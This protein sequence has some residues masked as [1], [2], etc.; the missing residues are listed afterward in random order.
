[1]IPPLAEI[2]EKGL[3]IWLALLAVVVGMRC[4]RGDI[5]LAGLLAHDTADLGDARPAP[6]RVQLLVAFVFALVAYARLTLHATQGA[7][8]PLPT[9]LPEAPT[10]LVMLL[11][12]SQS[13]YLAGKLGRSI[14]RRG[15]T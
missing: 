9:Q 11:G 13:I 12:G 6:E 1:M 7:D 10:E 4:M 15:R 5:N 3:V 2:A 8:A 14:L